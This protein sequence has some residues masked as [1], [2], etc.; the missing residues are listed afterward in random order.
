MSF[1]TSTQNTTNEINEK[2]NEN[3]G[4]GGRIGTYIGDKKVK[5]IK[6]GK[7]KTEN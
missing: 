4:V 6:K 5:I 2:K 7:R 1:V 3:D